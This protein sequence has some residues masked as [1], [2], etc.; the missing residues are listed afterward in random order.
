MDW[1]RRQLFGLLSAYLPRHVAFI[2]DGNRRWARQHRLEPYAGHP[3]GSSKLIQTAQWCFDA[4]IKYVSVF[5]FA[6]EN[7]KRS[8]DEVAALMALAESRFELILRALRGEVLESAPVDVDTQRLG[9]LLHQHGVRIRIVG[10]LSLL[11]VRVR[12][13][14]EEIN[15][16]DDEVVTSRLGAENRCLLNICVAYSGREEIEKVMEQVRCGIRKEMLRPVDVDATLFSA[17][18]WNSDPA[19][20]NALERA[21]SAQV[22]LLVRTSAE[23][24]LS[25]FLL[26]QLSAC[27][28]CGR[29]AQLEFVDAM[30][31]AFGLWDLL[32]VLGRYAHAERNRRALQRADLR[33]QTC[34]R[35]W[36]HPSLERDYFGTNSTHLLDRSGALRRRQ[37]AFIQWSDA[38]SRLERKEF[39]A[40]SQYRDGAGDLQ[41]PRT[42]IS[43]PCPSESAGPGPTC[44]SSAP[45]ALRFLSAAQSHRVSEIGNDSDCAC[46]RRSSEP[47][48]ERDAREQSTVRHI[49]TPSPAPE[50]HLVTP[51]H[52]ERMPRS[53]APICRCLPDA[54]TQDT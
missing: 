1:M 52:V 29:E 4:G 49:P 28:T 8:E 25:D 9:K 10:A 53:F 32:V 24:R 50:C 31:P 37:S 11:P 43:A 48:S 15:A 7:F 33:C 3:R 2:M 46:S 54:C 27:E 18:M 39:L 51:Q 26:W 23:P 41:L 44:W 38:C 6:V 34:G 47:C 21:Y 16:F 14:A 22:D 12:C 42:P 45:A 20:N 19:W 17:L 40:R 13:L 30:W 35:H 36:L 5:A